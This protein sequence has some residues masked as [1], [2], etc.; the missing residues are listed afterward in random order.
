[1][2]FYCGSVFYGIYN[3]VLLIL[4]EGTLEIIFQPGDILSP[5]GNFV[6]AYINNGRHLNICLVIFCTYEL[7]KRVLILAKP[8]FV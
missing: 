6:Y 5:L 8:I 2:G 3:I 7:D 1:M 4:V